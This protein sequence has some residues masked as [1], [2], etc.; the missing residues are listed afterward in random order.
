[1]PKPVIDEREG[2]E[3]GI[4]A[5]GSTDPPIAEA[6][7]HAARAAASRP[8]I[9]ALRALPLDEDSRALSQKYERVYVVEN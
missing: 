8:A 1:M 9:C 7:D 5:Y 6:R 2:A 4:I 3:I